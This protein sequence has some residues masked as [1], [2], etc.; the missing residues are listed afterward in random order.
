MLKI[1]PKISKQVLNMF[2]AKFFELI[3]MPSV[4]WWVEFSKVFKKSK[5]FQNFK[6]AQNRSQKCPNVF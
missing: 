1:V 4:P 6:N 5:S 2:R 3:F